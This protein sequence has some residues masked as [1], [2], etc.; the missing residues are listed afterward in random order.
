MCFDSS[1]KKKK[2]KRPSSPDAQPVELAP[3]IPVPR[4]VQWVEPLR[5]L[6]YCHYIDVEG[7]EFM[8]PVYGIKHLRHQGPE[9]REIAKMSACVE[10]GLL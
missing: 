4:G 1:P 7:T 6:G 10:D 9:S 5:D 2:K 3:I 8:T